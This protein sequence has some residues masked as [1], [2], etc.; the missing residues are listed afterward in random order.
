MSFINFLLAFVVFLTLIT[1]LGGVISYLLEDQ[2]RR[3]NP[4]WREDLFHMA[5]WTKDLKLAPRHEQCEKCDYIIYKLK[6]RHARRTE[7]RRS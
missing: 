6:E 5:Y 7:A 1:A 3:R 4:E 2:Y